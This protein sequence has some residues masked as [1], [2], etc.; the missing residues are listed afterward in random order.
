MHSAKSTASRRRWETKKSR[1]SGACGKPRSLLNGCADARPA[2]WMAQPSALGWIQLPR[3]PGSNCCG[4]LWT[5][6]NWKPAVRKYRW[7]TS[8]SGWPS[9]G[10]DIRRRQRGLLLLTAHRAKG[11]EFDHVAVLDGGWERAGPDED[12]DA[13]RRLYYVA[14]T[15]ARYTLALVCFPG[16]HSLQDTLGS[17]PAVLRRQA[18]KLPPATPELARQYRRPGLNEIDLG[19]AGRHGTDHPVHRAIADLSPDDPLRPRVN[20]QG[21]WELLN[22]S[23]NGRWEACQQ[24]PASTRDAVQFRDGSR[25]RGLEPRD[26]GAAI[27]GRGDMRHLGSGGTGTGVRLL[28]WRRSF[29]AQAGLELSGISLDLIMLSFTDGTHRSAVRTHCT[30]PARAA[31]QCPPGKPASAQCHSVCCRA[32]LQVAELAAAVRQVAH[33][34]EALR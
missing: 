20:E 32:G 10:R 5:N 8:S 18:P 34:I 24:L 19:F 9:G 23:G 33:I 2:W 16:S 3:V 25:H 31:R 4:K 1:D 22:Q 14:M 27:Q 28:V 15:R 30:L 17:L 7:T 11:L 21:R 13:P 29:Q 6:T 26:I 12:P